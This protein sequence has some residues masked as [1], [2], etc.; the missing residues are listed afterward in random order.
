[1]FEL[2]DFLQTESDKDLPDLRSDGVES[3]YS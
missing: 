3:I 2:E 1:M